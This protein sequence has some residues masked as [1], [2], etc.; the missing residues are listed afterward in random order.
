MSEIETNAA[1][2][3]SG[4][5]A[6]ADGLEINPDLLVA[7]K[8]IRDAAIKIEEL[9]RERDEARELLKLTEEYLALMGDELNETVTWASTHGWRSSRYEQGKA[10]R[11]KIQR[12]KEG[13]K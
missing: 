4:L 6:I 1:R 10:L 5:R 3:S 9:E 2:S 8:V 13:A 12:L 7:Q 11:E